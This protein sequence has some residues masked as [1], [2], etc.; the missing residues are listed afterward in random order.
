M[1][2]TAS[3]LWPEPVAVALL[4]DRAT[5]ARLARCRRT[6]VLQTAVRH[7][8]PSSDPAREAA[9]GALNPL[10]SA[11]SVE[12]AS[13]EITLS[14][15]FAR[16]LHLPS[17]PA[18]RAEADW[19]GFAQHR[20]AE[21]YGLRPDGWRILL[22]S[23]AR[24]SRLACAVERAL[25][26]GIVQSLSA[27][28]HRLRSLRPH[29]AQFFDRVRRRVGEGDAW[30]VDRESEQLTIALA[31]GGEWRAIRQRREPNWRERLAA[32][33]DREGELAGACEIE[34]VFV[35][36]TSGAEDM[37]PRLGRYAISGI[38]TG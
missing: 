3:R 9:V 30:L 2:S 25:I 35:A 29:F 14:N 21:L 27:A 33:L 13:V 32:I 10:L 31:I 37:P 5:G 38:G 22:S 1:K 4:A 24:S 6:K 7:F 18:L 23:G 8:A 26:D 19:Q 12:R 11:L 34:S 36:R 28:G 16:Y 17:S 15:R 20:F